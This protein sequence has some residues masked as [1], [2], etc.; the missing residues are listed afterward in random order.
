MKT[1]T[2]FVSNSS[3]SSY[4]V[5]G[6]RVEP[7]SYEEMDAIRHQHDLLRSEHLIVLSGSEDGLG[8][9]GYDG[10]SIIGR[11]L[12]EIDDNGYNY[13]PLSYFPTEVLRSMTVI[14]DS[15]I[16]EL[17]LEKLDREPSIFF[18]TRTL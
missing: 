12:I 17:G 13:I 11:L 8:D 15:V 7:L 3:S 18:G 5:F 14:I 9:N 10:Y 6:F 4:A 1:R 16:E 2:G